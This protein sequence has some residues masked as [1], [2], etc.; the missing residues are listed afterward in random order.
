MTRPR[1]THSICMFCPLDLVP[2]A[3][4]FGRSLVYPLGLGFEA[5]MKK[6]E[7]DWRGFVTPAWPSYGTLARAPV[8]QIMMRMTPASRD[9]NNDLWTAFSVSSLINDIIIDVQNPGQLRKGDHFWSV[10]DAN[11]L[12]LANTDP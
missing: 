3:Q 10:A 1:F 4:A 7:E 12:T 6:G 5:V 11:G 8:V 9:A 2:Q